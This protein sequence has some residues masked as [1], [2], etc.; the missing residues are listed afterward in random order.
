MLIPWPSS[1]LKFS[2]DFSLIKTFPSIGFRIPVGFSS[3]DFPIP[4]HQLI[5]L[6][7]PAGKLMF[8]FLAIIV[9]LDFV[10]YPIVRFVVS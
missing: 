4:W 1:G 10:L 9:V 3:V 6:N 2:M 7:F 8:R 5:Q